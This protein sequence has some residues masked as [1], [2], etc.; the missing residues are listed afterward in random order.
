MAGFTNKGKYRLLGLIKGGTLPTNFYIALATSA[1]APV[2]DTNTFTE[3]TEIAAG[4]GYTTGGYQLTPNGTDFDTHAETDGSDLASLKIK[5][6]VW[7]ASG[8][9]IPG[10]G[11]GARYAVL[12]DDNVT[13]ASREVWAYWDLTSDRTV[14]NTQTLTLQD[15]EL[16][17]TE[18]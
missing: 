11:N 8:G 2:A 15:L 1:A 6:V 13:I 4:N 17:L 7:T 12:L 16:Q 9:S 18:S 5:D 14:S 10:S 3:L